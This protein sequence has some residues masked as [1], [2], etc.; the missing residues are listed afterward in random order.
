MILDELK[1][2]IAKD[3]N[4]DTDGITMDTDVKEGLEADSLDLIEVVNDVEDKYGIAIDE[5]ED[6][7]TVGDLVRMIE[8]K[9]K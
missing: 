4:K 7:K 8:E 6:I 9:I 2:I 3:L 1:E 5:V